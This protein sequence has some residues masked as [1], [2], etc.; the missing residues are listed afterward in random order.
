MYI[1]MTS[2]GYGCEVITALVEWATWG[3]SPSSF[4][5]PLHIFIYIVLGDWLATYTLTVLGSFE[6]GLYASE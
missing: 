5:M 1:G 3:V 2:S 6:Q 4:K